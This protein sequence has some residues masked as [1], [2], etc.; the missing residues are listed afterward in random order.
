MNEWMIELINEC[1]KEGM[2]EWMIDWINKW[3]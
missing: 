2:N 3:M 1:N